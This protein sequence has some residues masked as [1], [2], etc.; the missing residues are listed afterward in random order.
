MLSTPNNQR[1]HSHTTPAVYRRRRLAGLIVLVV[2]ALLL[3][4]FFRSCGR[5]GESTP[6]G[7][8][9]ALRKRL[10][11]EP[12]E[13]TLAFTG[14]L[15]VH[16]PLFE[17]ALE[18]GDGERYDFAPLFEEIRPY[19][20]D[21]DLAFCHV[22][23]PM[24]PGPP[25][26]YPLFNTPPELAQG[27]ATTGWDACSTAS[28]HTLDQGEEGVTETLRALDRAGVRHTGSATSA[29]QAQEPLILESG[30]AQVAFLA[31][32]SDTNGIP[33]PRPYSVNLFDRDRI[34]ADA[35]QAREEGA[36][37]VIVNLHWASE[38]APEYVTEPN[39][40]Q[41]EL[42]RELAGVPAITAIV[43]QGP[44]VVQ[45]IREVAGKTVVFSE[46]NL[47]SNQGVDTGLAAASQDGYI[48][49]LDLMIDGDGARITNARY[50][51]TWVDH[52]DY[53]VLPAGAALQSGEA[54]A[55][56]LRASYERTVGVVGSRVATP[57]PASVSK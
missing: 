51:P 28:N 39:Q 47:I 38:V 40:A 2:L 30:G 55:T 31:Y 26:G 12:V 57:E 21:A 41:R 42:V 29:R 10:G 45:P 44:H 27:I 4:L 8:T 7:A 14:D 20:A 24:T 5:G 43:G 3:V 34:A 16:A 37:A 49:F 11:A 32:A 36:D 13:L 48:A 53:R 18:L 22:E 15:L 17:R 35:L 6:F 46:G 52:L 33:V 56:A 19:V 9:D 54:N 23:T 25:A 1:P 50:V